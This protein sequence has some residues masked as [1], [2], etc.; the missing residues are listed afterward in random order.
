MF[1][2]VFQST[3]AGPSQCLEFDGY[4]D[5]GKHLSVLASL[6]GECVAKVPSGHGA[7]DRL[8]TILLSLNQPSGLMRQHSS[9]Q[10]SGA[11][12]SEPSHYQSLHRN[13]F[14]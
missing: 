5:L 12:Y 8:R 14:R 1:V 11:R 6:L 2:C 9:P 7:T 4:I 3:V 13:I 10:T